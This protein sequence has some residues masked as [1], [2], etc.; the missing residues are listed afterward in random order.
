MTHLTDEALLNRI[1]AA[2]AGAFAALYDRYAARVLGVLL[3]L[4]RNRAEAEDVLQEAFLQI[5]ARAGQY[6]K[7]RASP[8]V[9]LL[10]IARSRAMDHL[11]RNRRQA[12]AV[13]EFEFE[14]EAAPTEDVTSEIELHES[15][16]RAREALARLPEEQR[17]AINLAF[18]G[19]LTHEQIA[20]RQAVPLGTVKT[21]IRLGMRRLREVFAA[22]A[23]VSA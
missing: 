11:R 9:W 16:Q 5:W 12:N 6:D 18:Y 3:K 20:E 14:A 2:D 13:A 10:L 17:G 7:T 21:R 23:K 19:G 4:L 8:L 15:A 22:Q 1:A